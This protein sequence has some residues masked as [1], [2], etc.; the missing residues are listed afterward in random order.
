MRFGSDGS[1]RSAGSL[2]ARRCA[3]GPA[4]LPRLPADCR[5]RPIHSPAAPLR[6]GLAARVL[7]ARLGGR[8]P[9]AVWLLLRTYCVLAACLAWPMR[10]PRRLAPAP[11]LPT[12]RFGTWLSAAC[13]LPCLGRRA[14]PPPC[15]APDVLSACCQACRLQL[16]GLA[17]SRLLRT[18]LACAT[19]RQ[20]APAPGS[21]AESRRA[22]PTRCFRR[23][24]LASDVPPPGCS[25][26]R[27]RSQHPAA[28]PVA[29]LRLGWLT[30]PA[31]DCC[32]VPCAA[33][34]CR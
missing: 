32:R 19:P 8:A 18:A 14:T 15:S 13:C 20:L 26:P 24:A 6:S 28:A 5:A 27:S 29:R 17:D 2:V 12:G 30:A 22:W 1:C 33:E 4:R 9:P 25:G 7:L 11:S 23:S 10:H 31:P 34:L 3:T 16:S 21:P